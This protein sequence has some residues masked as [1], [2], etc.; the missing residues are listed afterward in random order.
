MDKLNNNNANGN[1]GENCHRYSYEN[2]MNFILSIMDKIKPM[3]NDNDSG[4]DTTCWI[5]VFHF[6]MN[7][8]LPLSVKYCSVIFDDSIALDECS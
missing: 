5:W 3:N 8:I 4:S 2:Q 1:N 7:R 6:Q